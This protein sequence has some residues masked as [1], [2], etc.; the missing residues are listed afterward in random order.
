LNRKN[1]ILL[2]SVAVILGIAFAITPVSKTL[3]TALAEL[4]APLLGAGE[5]LG[6]SHQFFQSK[7]DLITEN[8]RLAAENQQLRQQIRALG[9][10]GR[11]NLR[12]REL[13]RFTET[14]NFSVIGAR[15][16]AR[17]TSSWWRTA[18]IDRGSRDG[19]RENQ[20]VLGASGLVGKVHS[21]TPTTARVLLLPDPNCKV[22]AMLQD[23]RHV[24]VVAGLDQPW[25]RMS[26]VDKDARISVGETVVTSGLGGV[27]PKGIVVGTVASEPRRGEFGLYQEFDIKPATDFSKL[28]EVL[29]VTK[30]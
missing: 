17:D 28:E 2:G 26:F 12:L 7:D 15:V 23:S 19:V 4:V 9:E 14:H 1:W 29:V 11:E 24:G 20:A 6:Q 10:V 25:L 21:V 8:A 22:S 30:P 18:L 3:Q 27:F 16:I 5:K 13:L